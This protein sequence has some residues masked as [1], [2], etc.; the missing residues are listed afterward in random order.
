MNKY[1]ILD[2][3]T[4][5]KEFLQ[6]WQITVDLLAEIAGV[7][8]AL[9]MRVHASEIEVFVANHMPDSVYH[10]GETVPLNTG[11]YCETVM[12]T[13]RKL[14]VPNA[15]KDPNWDNNPDIKLGMISYCGLPL[16]WPNGEIF[17]TIC[18]LDQEENSYI[19]QTHRLIE[20]FRDSIQLSLE[21]I[22]ESSLIRNQKEATE[23]ELRKSEYLSRELN[24]SILQLQKEIVEREHAEAVVRRLNAELE[25][26]VAQRTAQ[27]EAANEEIEEFS[28]SMSHDMRTPL[29]ALDG[30]SK[31]LLEEHSA[32]LDNEGVRL[33]KVLRNNAQYM[34]QMIDDILHFLGLGRQRMKFSSF[35]I[36][37][38]AS[39]VF[40]ELQAA[41]PARHLRLEIGTLPPAWGDRN[42]I[43]EVL[44][45]LLSNAI[46]FSPMDVDA[47]IKVDGSAEKAEIVYSVMDHGIGFDMRYASKLFKVFERVHSTG[48][49]KGSGIGLASVKRIVT[50]HD[51][52]VWAEGKFNEGAKFYFTLPKKMKGHGKDDGCGHP[53]IRSKNDSNRDVNLDD[54]MTFSGSGAL[55]W[56][57]MHPCL[58]LRCCYSLMISSL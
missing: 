30:F 54:R 32:N 21:Q 27:L 34:G 48:Q 13:Q 11:L 6:N 51:G 28:Y 3:I 38:L 35:D 44:Q 46:K 29:R 52:R 20:R 5:P 17:G 57:A 26:R 16:T 47:L 9:I 45:N 18:I 58:L 31:I 2:N 41:A 40:T 8:S 10:S 39:E 50:R 7:P 12:S 19:E 55:V 53:A 15:L 14:L 23:S 24:L 37:K 56:P 33:L 42:M 36:A 1:P 25:N 4:V 43:R 49:Y 22:Y